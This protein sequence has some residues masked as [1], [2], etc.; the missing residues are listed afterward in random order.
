MVRAIATAASDHAAPC[1]W[2]AH[3][4]LEHVPPQ[5]L[6]ASAGILYEE[7]AEVLV[8]ARARTMQQSAAIP[9]HTAAELREAEVAAPRIATMCGAL[10]ALLGGG[11][12]C[13]HVTEFCGVPGVGKTQLGIQ[14]SVNVQ[15]PAALHG[16]GGAAVYIDTEGSFMIDRVHDIAQ[17]TLQS[18]AD[19]VACDP[20]L[21]PEARAAAEGF[22]LASVLSRIHYFRIHS[23]SEQLALVTLLE[24]FLAQHPGV[25]LLVIDSVTFHF[26]Q[27]LKDLG[28]RA[29][30]LTGLAQD[31]MAL[32][33]AHGLAVVLMNQVATRVQGE[34]ASR[35]VP[36]LGESWGQAASTRVILHWQ[37]ET[38]QAL[39]Y[40]SPSLPQGVAQYAI[41]QGGVRD[42]AQ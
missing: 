40:K 7:A 5:Q 12:A 29:R 8:L 9:S 33:E 31:L 10:D 28:A 16:V 20:T 22:S 17:A 19:H 26:R 11:V 27:D 6:A 4:T 42:V 18:V 23:A 41:V 32:A 35:L 34:G 13:G 15:I 39:M 14:L 37:G 38:R 21:S 30:V 36:A 25:R 3:E 1:S 2:S 24:P